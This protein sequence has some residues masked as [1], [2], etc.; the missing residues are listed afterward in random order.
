MKEDGAPMSMEHGLRARDE[1]M[2]F[3][4][5]LIP[6]S[7]HKQGSRSPVSSGRSVTI[8]DAVDENKKKQHLQGEKREAPAEDIF[9]ESDVGRLRQKSP[10]LK[11][12]LNDHPKKRNKKNGDG[13]YMELIDDNRGRERLGDEVNKLEKRSSLVSPKSLS[14]LPSSGARLRNETTEGS[15][16]EQKLFWL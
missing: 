1:H 12:E 9:G 8:K 13:D 14:R 10:S 4:H 2:G 5:R 15:K 7:P 11:S 3:D 6:T 16:K